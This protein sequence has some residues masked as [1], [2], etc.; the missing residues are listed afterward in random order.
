MFRQFPQSDWSALGD[1]GHG[2]QFYETDAHLIE[3]LACYV[4]TALVTGDVAVVIATR[5]HRVAL[6]KRL[7]SR[8]MNVRIAARGSRYITLDADGTLAKLCRDDAIDEERFREVI[9]SAVQRACT[10][11][12]ADGGRPRVYVFAEMVGL[13][14]LDGQPE[15]AIRLEELWNGLAHEYRFALCCAYPMNGFTQGHAAP[16]MRICAQHSHVFPAVERT[17]SAVAAA[18]F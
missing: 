9:G 17:S 14:C 15:E 10:T 1:R 7:T 11:P 8:G 6:D 2:V 13:L 3:M 12:S 4:G 5:P 18:H 16:F